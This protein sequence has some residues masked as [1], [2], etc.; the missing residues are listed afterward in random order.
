M[1]KM[2]LE[3]AIEWAAETL[4]DGWSVIIEVENGYGGV[5]LEDPDGVRTEVHEDEASF[6][7]LVENA[8]CMSHDFVDG[9]RR[10]P[11]GKSQ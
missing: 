9:G 4:D 3:E 6:A 10:V 1:S 7:T 5:V 11:E 8:V 2:T